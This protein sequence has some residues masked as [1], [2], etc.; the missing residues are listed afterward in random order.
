MAL[1]FASGKEASEDADKAIHLLEKDYQ[2]SILITLS[3]P[4]LLFRSTLPAKKYFL[5]EELRRI[6]AP[7][8]DRWYKEGF[9]IGRCFR[10]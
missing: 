6:Q 4:Y 8:A 10:F 9:D 5:A 2:S 3:C 1:I 7:Q